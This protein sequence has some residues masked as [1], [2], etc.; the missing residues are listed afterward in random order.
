MKVYS[1]LFEP[2]CDKPRL[3]LRKLLSQCIQY[4]ISTPLFILLD[5]GAINY[6]MNYTNIM[7]IGLKINMPVFSTRVYRIQYVR[8]PFQFFL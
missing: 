2:N 3:V 7:T 8:L 5:R 4:N 6:Y 1:L